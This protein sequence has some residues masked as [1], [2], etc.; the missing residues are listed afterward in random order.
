MII[1]DRT[2]SRSTRR[3]TSTK[4]IKKKA[5]IVRVLYITKST[6]YRIRLYKEVS[7]NRR[8]LLKKFTKS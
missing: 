6:C 2:T 4:S 1:L 5:N 3:S 7:T 8:I